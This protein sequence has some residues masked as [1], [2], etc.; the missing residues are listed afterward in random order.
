MG[1]RRWWRRFW[2]GRE[3]PRAIAL[4]RIVF[5]FLVICDVNDLWEHFGFLFTDEG[6]F[7]ADVARQV[8]ARRQ[9]AGFGDGMIDGEPWG[10]FDLEAVGRFL[11]GPKFSLLYFWDT[12]AAAWIHIAALELVAVAFM[13]GLSTRASAIVCFALMISLFDRNPLFWE[14]T[15]LAFRVFFVYLLFARSGHAWSVDNWLRCRRLRRLGRA[16]EPVYRMIPAW[17]RHLMMLQLAVVFFTTGALKHGAVWMRGDAVYYALNLDHFYRFPPQQL[18]ALFGT[19]LLRLVTWFV[20]F[21]EI[22]FALVFVGEVLRVAQEHREGPESRTWRVLRWTRRWILG[23]RIWVTWAVA[24]MGGIF[25]VMNI[26]QFQPVMLCACL[27]YFRGEEVARV[28]ARALRRP[29]PIAADD[30]G[31]EWAYGPLGRFCTGTLIAWHIAAVAIWLVPAR[32]SI[33]SI[34]KPARALVRPWLELTRTTQGWGMFAPNPPRHN[35]F[36]RVLVTDEHGEV[37][38]LRSDVYAEEQRAI[39]FI[40][41]D[42]MRKMNRR[43]IGGEGDGGSWYRKWYAR[44]QCRQWALEHDGRVP[45]DVQLVKVSY[46]IPTP[47]AVREHGWYRPEDRLRTHGKDEL[48]HT[49]RCVTA[50]LGQPLPEVALRHGITSSARFRPWIKRRRQAWENRD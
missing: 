2:L 19:N 5:A 12:P 27:L 26:G 22:G 24:T 49:E 30:D 45:K 21:G 38:D 7:P 16:D 14:G 44:W 47:E 25:V 32:D 15:E 34:R 50:V 8:F 20:R 43:I 4:F 35:V 23:R 36:M 41:N 9:F 31:R 3:D 1:P 33:E 46:A 37:W 39:P 48:V 17:P 18:S 6:I 13:I 29:A 42:R 10:F 11:G 28:V 40:W